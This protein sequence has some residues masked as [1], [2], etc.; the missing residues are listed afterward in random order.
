MADDARSIMFA[1]IIFTLIAIGLYETVTILS[2]PVLTIL[3]GQTAGRQ[4]DTNDTSTI[5]AVISMSV[6][7]RFGVLP[8]IVL[9][10]VLLLIWLQPIKRRLTA[11]GFRLDNGPPVWNRTTGS[12][13]L[14]GGTERTAEKMIFRK[15]STLLQNK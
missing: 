4:F 15:L 13:R 14:S 9:V 3:T 7:G 1:R 5:N 2:N 12:G 10:A 8:L 11:N 6:Y